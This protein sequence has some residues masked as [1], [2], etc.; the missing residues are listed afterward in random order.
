VRYAVSNVASVKGSAI[1]SR[2]RYV[3]DHHGEEGYRLLMDALPRE[4]RD[5]IR[6]RILPHAWVPYELF[7]QVNIEADRLFGRGDL[8]L[9][10]EMG[11]FSAELNLPTLYRLF[12]RL[13]TPMFIFRKASQLW[14]VHYDSGR[15]TAYEDGPGVVRLCMEEFETP[16][17]AH[18]LSVLGW[19][20]KSIELSGATVIEAEEKRCR[21]HADPA[22]E[23]LLRWQ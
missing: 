8:G 2:I 23:L 13:G 22:C 15:M 12:Y 11:R 1:T 16:H 21:V 7:I 10:Y 6:Q 18:C 9:C 20:A 4:G 17:R 19:A 3:R 5:L 14:N